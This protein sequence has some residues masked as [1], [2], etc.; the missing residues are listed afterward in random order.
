[1]AT[2]L[3]KSTDNSMGPNGRFIRDHFYELEE[4]LPFVQAWVASG[5][6]IDMT[7]TDRNIQPS[8]LPPDSSSPP[9]TPENQE[10]V[11]LDISGDEPVVAPPKPDRR[12]K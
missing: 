2:K 4:S 6:L 7:P 10:E 12:K 5:H 11:E 1:M 9:D 3:Y 8:P